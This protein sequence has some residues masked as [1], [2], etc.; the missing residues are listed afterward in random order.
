LRERKDKGL[1]LPNTTALSTGGSLGAKTS[2]R[3]REREIGRV[4]EREREKFI[5]NQ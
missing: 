4:R 2:W 5:D 1:R 3:E